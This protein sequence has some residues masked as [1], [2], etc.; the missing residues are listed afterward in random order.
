MTDGVVRRSVRIVHG[1]IDSGKTRR[2]AAW[3][4][5]Q[6]AAGVSVGGILAQKTPEGRRFFDIHTGDDVPL[7]HPAAGEAAVEVGRF[8]FRQAAFD[9]AADRVSMAVAAG[10]A[11]IVFDEVGPLEMRGG[12]FAPLLD[13]LA[14][15]MPG[16]ELVL[17]VRTSLIDV[18][19]ERFAQAAH[20]TYDP[21]RGDPRA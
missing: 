8:H 11:V 20:V 10:G 3:I 2:T 14:R 16:V 13:R 1:E 12:G 21:P 15:D 7:E 4:A 19:V 6:G 9:W 17:L 5:E 18:V